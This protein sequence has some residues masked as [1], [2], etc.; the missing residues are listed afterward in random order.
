M[1][2]AQRP[3]SPEGEIVPWRVLLAVT[4]ATGVFLLLPGDLRHKAHLV[5][6]GVCAQRPSHSFLFAGQP[7]PVDARMTGIYLGAASALLWFLLVC[8]ARRPGRFTRGAWMVLALCI[9]VMALDGL[10]SLATDLAISTPYASTNQTRLATGLLAGVAIGALLSHLVTISLTHRP[11]GG[12]PAAP[13]RSLAPP[14]VLGTALCALAASGLP[15]LALPFTGLILASALAVLW[16]MTSVL[17]ALALRRGWGFV[18]AR[19]R[20][21]TLAM[22]FVSACVLLIG[23]AAW[24]VLLEHAVGPLRLS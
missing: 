10:N 23:L 17:A 15:A 2:V 7:L 1:L 16:A 11:R 12:W 14:L 6:Q 9:G 3:H 8:R 5:L 4:V 19:Q 13:T 20:D 21:E 24:R 22:A 18:S